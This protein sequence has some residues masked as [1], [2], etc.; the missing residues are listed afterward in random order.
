[1]LGTTQAAEALKFITGVGDLLVNQLLIF[2]A[3]T[4]RFRTVKVKKNNNCPLCGDHPQISS[5]VDYEQ[6]VCDLKGNH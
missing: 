2:D 5:L 3:K 4:M 6:A 1:M